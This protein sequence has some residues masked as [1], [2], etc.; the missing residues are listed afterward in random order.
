M[1]EM[2]LPSSPS[3]SLLLSL[4]PSSL[5][6]TLTGANRTVTH[7]VPVA[8]VPERL[9]PDYQEPD[10]PDIDVRMCVCGG[11]QSQRMIRERPRER[12]FNWEGERIEQG[13]EGYKTSQCWSVLLCV[14]LSLSL[15]LRSVSTCLL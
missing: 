5:Q 1:G 13:R 12:R 6:P 9:W 3:L 7:D 10:M 14:S 11:G 2:L 8:V 15:S 4:P